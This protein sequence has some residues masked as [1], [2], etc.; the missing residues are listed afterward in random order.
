MDAGE[1]FN[2]R[3]RFSAGVRSLPSPHVSTASTG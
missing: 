2:P 1:A 3:Y